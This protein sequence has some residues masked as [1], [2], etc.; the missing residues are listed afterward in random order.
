MFF[1]ESQVIFMT[2][3][4]YNSKWLRIVAGLIN[5]FGHVLLF[6]IPRRKFDR[7]SIKRALIIK[8]DRIG[9]TFLATPT[10]EAIREL[11]PNARITVLC[12][13][14]NRNVLLSNPNID[15]LRS[16]DRAPDVHKG[17]MIKA[18]KLRY[19]SSLTKDIKKHN[20]EML[21][22]LQ[23]NPL[24]VLAGFLAKVPIRIGF[25]R[26][27][28]SFLMTERVSYADNIHQS[29][30]YFSIARYLGYKRSKPAPR[31]FPDGESEN[32]ERIL[33]ENQLQDFLVFHLG[34]GRS[35]RQWPV[36]HF[37]ALANQLL[38]KQPETEIVLIGNEKE[39]GLILA[40]LETV[41]GKVVNLAGRITI[42]EAYCLL[43]F[44]KGFVGNESGPAHLSAGLDVPTIMLMNEW[45][46][47]ERW[48]A[49]GKKVYII[50]GENRHRCRGIACQIVPCPNM[51]SISVDQVLRV[52]ENF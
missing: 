2:L 44:S 6:W 47:I 22:D 27:V 1:S 15:I 14:W 33:R 20:P 28:L 12:S 46:G 52:V 36:Q 34:A 4:D 19:I 24:I 13:P 26:K 30:V 39:Q 43:S 51:A 49:S 23:G 31:I 16:F 37:A 42:K 17:P 25:K 29:D 10:I 45:S 7:N 38:V 11:F 48:R 21:I 40:F 9:D 32:V 18:L 35:Y 50:K 41:R 5:F 8:L 3:P